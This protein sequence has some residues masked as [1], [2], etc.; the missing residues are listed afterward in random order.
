MRLRSLSGDG[1]VYLVPSSTEQ[2]EF[3]NQ[4]EETVRPGDLTYG[5]GAERRATAIPDAIGAGHVQTLLYVAGKREKVHPITSWPDDFRG[6][7]W[8]ASL[9]LLGSGKSNRVTTRALRDYESPYT[10]ADD[11]NA[12]VGPNGKRWPASEDELRER[13]YAIL[14]KL[15]GERAGDGPRVYIVAAGVG[16]NGTLAA[17]LFLR[18]SIQRIYEEY[19]TS[20]FAYVLS[21][22]RDALD[23]FDPRVEAHCPLPVVRR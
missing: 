16:P 17:C 15:K 2:R 12:I 20:P 6:S 23:D 8:A 5:T 18:R 1:D 14:V 7:Y 4:L 9:V 11:F 21:V 19:D 13:D 10:F 22:T 3:V